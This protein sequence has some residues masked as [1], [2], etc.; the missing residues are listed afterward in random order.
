MYL[1]STELFEKELFICIKMYLA[2]NDLHRLIFHKT[3]TNK[4]TKQNVH[5]KPDFGE[6]L[7]ANGS[8]KLNDMNTH[9]LT[10]ILISGNGIMNVM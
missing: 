7:I 4:L 5:L 9:C 3:Q 1:C 8:I 10:W 2:L 6:E